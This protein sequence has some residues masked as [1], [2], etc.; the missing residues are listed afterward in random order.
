MPFGLARQL[1]VPPLLRASAAERASLLAGPAALAEPLLD[2]FHAAARAG[3]G[4]AGALVE[5]LHWL[6]VNLAQAHADG[7]SPA[8]LAIVVDD[9]QWADRPSLRLLAHLAGQSDSAGFCVVAA[10]RTG[11]P[12]E[13]A[14]CS[15]ACAPSRA[16]CGCARPCSPRRRSAA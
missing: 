9:A 5:G 13:R 4:Q 8:R 2:G 6:A 14:T 1:F 11:E 12:G 16:A 15:G 3:E 10:V 7:P